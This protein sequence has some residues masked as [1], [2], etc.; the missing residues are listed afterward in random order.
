MPLGQT[1]LIFCFTDPAC[2]NSECA[3]KKYC[4]GDGGARGYSADKHALIRIST[5]PC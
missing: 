3:V 1:K 5:W 4:V 2:Q